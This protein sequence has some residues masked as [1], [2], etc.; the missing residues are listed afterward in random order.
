MQRAGRSDSYPKLR[1]ER[2][3]WVLVHVLR[4]TWRDKKQIWKRR[5]WGLASVRGLCSPLLENRPWL[6]PWEVISKTMEED[7]KTRVLWP[8]SSKHRSVLGM[9]F[10]VPPKGS[11]Q[12]W[13][14]FRWCHSHVYG[15]NLFLSWVACPCDWTLYWG[16]SVYPPSTHC[17]M[18]WIKLVIA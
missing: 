14:D 2:K 5:W 3:G 10:R 16:D 13:A 11:G 7:N 1:K 4:L 18:L 9:R 12:A 17:L 6:T 15:K 8:V